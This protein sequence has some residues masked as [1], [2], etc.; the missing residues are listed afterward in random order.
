MEKA[1]I[2]DVTESGVPESDAAITVMFNP[3]ELSIKEYCGRKTGQRNSKRK[4]QENVV[5][6]L[7]LFFNT[8]DSMWQQSYE[9][10]RNQTHKF[11]KYQN[12]DINKN[13]SYKEICF[14][15]G[16]ICIIGILSSFSLK[17]T[18]FTADG[19]PVRA[20]ASLEISGYYYGKDSASKKS[21]PDFLNKYSEITH[22]EM[23]NI[24]TAL[25]VKESIRKVLLV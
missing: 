13:S 24:K 20:E 25:K 2:Y 5:L 19:I 8:Y 22:I 4:Q 16:S 10:V 18:M 12:Q 3:N 17:Y 11:H 14:N 23:D 1:K 7:S 21:Q 15:W 9:D 6:S